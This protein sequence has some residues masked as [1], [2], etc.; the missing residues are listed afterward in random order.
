MKHSVESLCCLKHCISAQI[1][2]NKRVRAPCFGDGEE[3]LV[4]LEMNRA[5]IKDL[6]ASQHQELP[7]AKRESGMDFRTQERERNCRHL[8]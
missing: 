5:V 3:T 6:G 8:A 2:Y 4:A 1:M 7:D